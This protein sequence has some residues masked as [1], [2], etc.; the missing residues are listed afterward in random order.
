MVKKTDYTPNP[1]IS[2]LIKPCPKVSGDKRAW[3]IPVFGVWVPFFTGKNATGET[4]ISHEALGAPVRLAKDGNGSI[5]FTKSGRPALKLIKELADQVRIVKDNLVA[6]LVADTQVIRDTMPDA[7]QAQVEANQKA[8]EA[9]YRLEQMTLT[10][11]L[12]KEEA[13]GPAK[14]PVPVGA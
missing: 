8:G 5:K 6:G 14:E 12:E 1:L 10:N 9:V 11:Y 13:T 2:T 3:S 7:Y 4:H